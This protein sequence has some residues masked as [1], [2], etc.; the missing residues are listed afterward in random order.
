[1]NQASSAKSNAHHD[2][3]EQSFSDSLGAAKQHAEAS[4]PTERASQHRAGS[5]KDTQADKTVKRTKRDQS[6]STI[7]TSR[8]QRVDETVTNPT[9]LQLP[10][11]FRAVV[12]EAQGQFDGSSS[13]SNS[14][15]SVA[16]PDSPMQ[17]PSWLN[18]SGGQAWGQQP[19]ISNPISR[20]QPGADASD[21]TTD[22]IDEEDG[23]TQLADLVQ[24]MSAA[25]ASPTDTKTLVAAP[26]PSDKTLLADAS[27]AAPATSADKAAAAAVAQASAASTENAPV[28]NNSQQ[29]VPSGSNISAVSVSKASIAFK[30]VQSLK[31]SPKDPTLSTGLPAGAKETDSYLSIQKE[32]KSG[33]DTNKDSTSSS[34]SQ[35]TDRNQTAQQS[36][37]TPIATPI[38]TSPVIN[39]H[40][41]QQ[42]V[43]INLN[44]TSIASQQKA[45]DASLSTQLQQ[46]AVATPSASSEHLSTVVNSAK[47]MQSISQSEMRVGM[48]TAEFGDISI[49][50]SAGRD[51]ISAQISLGHDDLAKTLTAHMPEMQTRLTT[52]EVVDVHIQSDSQT[53][54]FTGGQSG[55]NHSG[56]Q[57]QQQDSGSSRPSAFNS[58]SSERSSFAAMPASMV[59]SIAGNSNR[60]DIRA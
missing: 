29:T 40:V 55:A 49:R 54:S 18:I 2:A 8:L 30:T 15:H 25:P 31:S 37:V 51:S 57:S 42:P 41:H 60:L 4:A 12:D 53:G 43:A 59:A 44:D 16:I 46:A 50:T 7:D 13:V 23:A 14:E 5:S 58:Y 6:T 17:G 21:S 45:Q 48:R 19:G 52:G 24:N 56:A 3:G 20:A 36:F 11:N 10:T 32:A 26:A 38:Q 27:S 33:A 35:H 39:S 1:M 47:L 22:N 34:T 9:A 28:A